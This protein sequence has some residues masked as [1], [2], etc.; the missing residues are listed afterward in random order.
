MCSLRSVV[1]SATE[2]RNRRSSAIPISV[3]NSTAAPAR[4]QGRSR[5]GCRTSSEYRRHR[6]GGFLRARPP[7]G[8]E[9]RRLTMLLVILI[10]RHRQE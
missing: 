5:G 1:A 2:G 9:S 8:V 3:R 4:L 6:D 10:V 7:S